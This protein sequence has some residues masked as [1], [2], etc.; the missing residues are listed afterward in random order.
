MKEVGARFGNYHTEVGLLANDIGMIYNQEGRFGDAVAILATSLL[1]QRMDYSFSPT[2]TDKTIAAN[3]IAIVLVNMSGVYTRQDN[4]AEGH[5]A[6]KGALAI[7][8]ILHGEKRIGGGVSQLDR[9]CL[10]Q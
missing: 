1:I 3:N 4:P 6:M 9:C 10:P 2:G 7:H 5:K 8:R